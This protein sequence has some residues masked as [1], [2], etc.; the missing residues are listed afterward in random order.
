MS[1]CCVGLLFLVLVEGAAVG[2]S[3]PCPRLQAGNLPADFLEMCR[4]QPIGG[5][6]KELVLQS[7]PAEGEVLKFSRS[8]RKK[9]AAID[10]VL[11]LHERAGVY[12]VNV[13][14]LPSATT[15]LHGRA[16]LLV[17]L[18]AL[19]QLSEEE[20][21]ALTAH[22]IGHEFLWWEFV[23]AKMRGDS[24]RMRE[25]ELVSDIVAAETLRQ[26]G[27]PVERLMD[28]LVKIAAYNRER[29]GVAVN[30]DDYPRISTRRAAVKGWSAFVGTGKAIK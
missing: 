8:E 27:I 10:A 26:L 15:A 30:E 28:A 16:V 22:E 6:E 13:I 14:D 17:T 9:L 23:S 21:Q 29:L 1:K 3:D 25:L 7:L 18:P 19:T 12:K 5:G 24:V 20:L 2:Q 11:R 4:P